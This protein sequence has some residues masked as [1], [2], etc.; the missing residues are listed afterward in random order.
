MTRAGGNNRSMPQKAL[1]NSEIATDFSKFLLENFPPK[2]GEKR[3]TWFF[4]FSL[5]V[6]IKANRIRDLFSDR[7]CSMRAIE[8]ATI[9][10]QYGV[11][12]ER[13]I[14]A[15]QHRQDAL[16]AQLR[17]I[18]G[19]TSENHPHRRGV[20]AARSGMAVRNNRVRIS[21]SP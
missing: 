21:R 4:R 13:Q 16:A 20:R 19:N 18:K 3:S 15:L 7:R 1:E 14:I 10:Q 11:L 8:L 5:I 12:I 6:G 9:Q 17:S 2:V